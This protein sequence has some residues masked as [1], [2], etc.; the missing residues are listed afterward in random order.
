MREIKTKMKKR[1]K[2]R[3][4]SFIEVMLSVAVVGLGIVAVMPL[5][6]VGISEAI[7]SRDQ[8]IGAMLV[9][10]G[11]ELVQN[12]RDSNWAKG[13]SAFGDGSVAQGG[14]PA[15]D[16]VGGGNNGCRVEYD[17]N[18]IGNCN[19]GADKQLQLT[20]NNFYKHSG[21]T[22]TKFYRKIQIGYNNPGGR[23][24]SNSATITSVVVWGSSVFPNPVNSSTCNSGTNNKKGCAFVKLTLTDW[25]P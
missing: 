20:A 12:Y 17:S 19:S 1:K 15:S 5:M 8:L 24:S 23:D 25:K 9:Q 18:S 6:A 2:I 10:E 21:G 22:A 4:F 14:F 7:T 13:L 11:A 3:G 16:Y